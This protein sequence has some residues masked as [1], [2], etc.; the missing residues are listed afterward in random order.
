MLSC[1]IAFDCTDYSG[2]TDQGTGSI[3]VLDSH[4]NGVPYAI[5][6]ASLGDEQPNIVLDNLLVENS[7]AVV[8]VSG[9]DT[10]LPGSAGALYFNSWASG[11]RYLPD[12]SGGKMTG[13][14]DPAPDKPSSLLDGTGAYFQQSK[15]QY[16]TEAPISATAHGVSNDGTGDQ[17][18]A[19]N[20]LLAGNAGSV[21]FFPGGVYLVEGTVKIPLGSRIVGSGWSQIMGTG[22]YFQD[23]DDPQ[24]LIQVGDE[25]DSGVIEI[26]DMLFT[27]K[28]PTAGAV[29]MEWN[30]HESA[31]GS[32]KWPD[33]GQASETTP[34]AGTAFGVHESPIEVL[35]C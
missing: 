2:V 5:T 24:V 28:G 27:V 29:L 19:I 12:G 30:V 10:I 32:G 1:Y 26:S 16:E 11:Y 35:G 9:G 14:V 18:A 6:I 22:T 34:Q 3:T 23:V 4:F 7:D 15:P 31:Q 8:L 13:F 25:G 20:A 33:G 17:T 21:I